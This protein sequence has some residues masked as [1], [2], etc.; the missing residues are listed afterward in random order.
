MKAIK[1]TVNLPVS[2]KEAFDLL[3][4]SKKIEAWSGQAGKVASKVGGKVEVFGKWAKGK[5]LEYKPAKSL[6]YTWIV[7]DWKKPSIVKYKFTKTK[8]GTKIFL[9]HSNLPSDKEVKDHMTGWDEYFFSPMK[10]YLKKQ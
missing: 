7:G 6:S 10:E 1:M 8:T 2:P 3:T 9:S 4:N 5:V